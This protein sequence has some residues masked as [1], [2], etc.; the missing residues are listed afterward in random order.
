MSARST[1][2]REHLIEVELHTASTLTSAL[3]RSRPADGANERRLPW[4]LALL[5]A[6][7]S[8][9]PIR[10]APVHEL[11]LGPQFIEELF[12]VGDAASDAGLLLPGTAFA[13][14]R[15]R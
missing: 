9:L 7:R 1:R 15:K 11:W 12:L 14:Y 3:R 13:V 4:W 10:V 5:R 2:L 8:R 6:L